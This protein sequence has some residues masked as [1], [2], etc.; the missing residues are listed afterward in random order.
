M[1]NILIYYSLPSLSAFHVIEV[2]VYGP[3]VNGNRFHVLSRRMSPARVGSVTSSATQDTFFNSIIREWLSFSLCFF[4]FFFTKIYL[5][6][7]ECRSSNES[8]I[9]LC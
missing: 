3:E 1:D 2:N 6:F 5:F 9:V 8:G 7:L 4:F